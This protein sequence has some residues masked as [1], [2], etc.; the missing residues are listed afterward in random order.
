MYVYNLLV[1]LRFW[2]L[3]GT[4]ILLSHV[5]GAFPVPLP[6]TED[7]PKLMASATLVCK[8]EVNAAPTPVSVPTGAGM[9]NMTATAFVHPDRCFKGDPHGSSV[10]V[11]FDGFV[12]SVSPSFVLRKGD[13]RLFFLKPHGTLYEVVNVW[14]G[15]LRISRELGSTPDGAHSMQLLEL[16]LKAGLR[17]ADPERVLD[18]VRMLGNMKHLRSKTELAALLQT[19]DL[20]VKTY[21]WQALLRLKDYSIMPQIEA[22]FATQPEAPHE[23][24]LPRDRLF[25]MQYEIAREIG[26]IRDANTLPY[27]QRFAESD[28][29]YLRT[30]AIDALRAI[31][32]PESAAVYLKQLDDSDPQIAFSAMHAL[33]E[34]SGGGPIAWVPTLPE[35]LE[36]PQFYEAKCREWWLTEGRSKASTRMPLGHT[37]LFPQ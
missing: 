17:D 33:I 27:L 7:I 24:S 6:G 9:P 13:Y 14:F 21:V 11:L 36:A 35:F 31:G 19:S 26:Q 3:A 15:A 8:G 2:V 10:P 29:H 30:H 22:F 18:S 20:L 12:A 34:L 23:L 5:A 32:S 1:H 16:D 4:L 25:Y 37:N 28:K